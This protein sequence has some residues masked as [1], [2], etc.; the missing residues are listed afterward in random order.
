MRRV[1]YALSLHGDEKASGP[2]VL[3][4][5]ILDVEAVISCGFE[6][7]SGLHRPPA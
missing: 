6:S 1:Y 2:A 7:G 4:S 3:R 5:E